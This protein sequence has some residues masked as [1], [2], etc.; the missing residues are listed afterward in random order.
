[1]LDARFGV[2][3]YGSIEHCLVKSTK[4]KYD[5]SK[6]G[7]LDAYRIPSLCTVDASRDARTE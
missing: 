6:K 7:N 2:L 5:H 4:I 1:L 3:T